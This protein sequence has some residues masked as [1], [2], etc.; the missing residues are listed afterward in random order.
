VPENLLFACTS[1][2][3]LPAGHSKCSF[4]SVVI[5]A[6]QLQVPSFFIFSLPISSVFVMYSS[7]VR[8][9]CVGL[10]V[11]PGAFLTL[12]FR[13]IARVS[14][15][16]SSPHFRSAL[17]QPVAHVDL[18]PELQNDFAAYIGCET[19]ILWKLHDDTVEARAFA[20]P[21]NV[22]EY[23]RCS[24][25]VFAAALSSP[26]PSHQFL[27]KKPSPFAAALVSP[28]TPLS[29]SLPLVSVA[30]PGDLASPLTVT[31][32][33]TLNHSSLRQRVDS[34]LE[35]MKCQHPE[36]RIG[37]LERE[38]RI[39]LEQI[40]SQKIKVDLDIANG[41]SSSL[42]PLIIV[43]GCK[44]CGK[45][46]LIRSAFASVE[47]PVLTS[48]IDCSSLSTSADSVQRSLEIC[49]A[50]AARRNAAV[51]ITNAQD[52]LNS[53]KFSSAVTTRFVSVLIRLLME[54]MENNSLPLQSPCVIS[55]LTPEFLDSNLRAFAQLEL[56]VPSPSL[57]DRAAIIAIHIESML[58][59]VIRATV[60]AEFQTGG[61]FAH[62]LSLTCESISGF[63]F[64]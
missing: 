40:C 6:T 49:F 64:V 14:F 30:T 45:C 2:N 31:H 21:P 3:S 8:D 39:L 56:G 10:V 15:P 57:E 41:H 51:I 22:A 35:K 37:G 50:S 5:S 4:N 43:H 25:S 29:N 17:P 32:S 23:P 24:P 38:A 55:C 44:G 16:A 48:E 7:C 61:K 36:L 54:K 62:V 53:R 33:S 28:S 20:P 26:K 58:H 1:L 34:A 60:V 42:R 13:T 19:R 63:R 46:S 18:P 27:N 59:P 47:P 11:V 9:A 12:P 52:M